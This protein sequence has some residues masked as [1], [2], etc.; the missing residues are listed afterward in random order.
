MSQEE[1]E[2]HQKILDPKFFQ[3][4]FFFVPKFFSDPTFISGPNFFG[5]KIFLDPK[6]FLGQN[7]FPNKIFFLSQNNFWTHF[8]KTQNDVW[9]EKTKL[10]KFNLS[11]LAKGKGFT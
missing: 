4:Q 10:L 6:F 3:T 5:P 7:F 8:F 2:Q 1:Q 11:K 9:R